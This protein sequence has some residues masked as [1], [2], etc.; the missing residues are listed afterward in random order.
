VSERSDSGATTAPAWELAQLLS[1]PN[2][3]EVYRVVRQARRPLTRDEVAQATGINRRLTTFH[4]D[5]LADAGFLSTDY[6]RPEGRRGGPGSGRP[7]K[8]YAASDVEVELS[9]PARH[10]V[11]AARLLAQAVT[12]DPSDAITSSH[13]VARTEGRRIGE[14]RR[15]AAGRISGRRA[16]AT[17]VAALEDLGYEPLDAGSGEIRL[18]NCPFRAVADLAPGLVCGMNRELVAGI[19]EGSGVDRGEAKP[20]GLAPDCCVIAVAPR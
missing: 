18:R 19:L 8:H 15:P 4:L 7:A 5:R 2:R 14:A 10:Y 6:A 16:R 20:G 17:A 9:V 1:E 11:F 12:A 13:R 3:R